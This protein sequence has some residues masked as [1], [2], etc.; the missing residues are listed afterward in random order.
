MRR[1]LTI[2]ML[3]SLSA[4]SLQALALGVG[5]AAVN[6]PLNAPLRATIPLTDTSGLEPELLRVSVAEPREFEAAGLTR[7]PLAASV[8]AAVQVREGQLVVDLITERAVREPWLDLMLSFEWP[9]GRQLR[10]VTLLL[11]P[12]D[13]DQ[14][15]VLVGLSP[16]PPAATTARSA[17]DPVREAAVP[18]LPGSV[19]RRAVRRSGLGEQWR[20]ALGRR[21]PAA[22]R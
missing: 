12:P 20:Y 19:A 18:G 15:P 21:R 8:R 13:Y 9:G 16:A 1:K 7:S 6:S 4:S 22:A 5:E 2:A 11:D 14:L 3:L 10:E 17:T